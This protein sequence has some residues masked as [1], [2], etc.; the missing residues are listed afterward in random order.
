MTKRVVEQLEFRKPLPV[1]EGN[2]DYLAYEAELIGI[3]RLLT[4]SGLEDVYVEKGLAGWLQELRVAAEKE[5]RRFTLPSVKALAQHQR[6][7]RQALRCNI[8]RELTEKEYRKFS[9]RLAESPLLQWFCRVDR[10]EKSLVP[11]KSTLERYDKMIPQSDV[12]VLVDRLNRQTMDEAERLHL[13]EAFTLDVCLSDTTCVKA[14]IHFPTDWV[15]LRDGVRTLMK[16]VKVIRQHGL[17]HRMPD[18]DEFLRDINRLSIEMSQSRRRQDSEKRR[19]TVLRRMKRLTKLVQ[20]HAQRYCSRL[21]TDWKTETDLSEGQ[22]KQITRRMDG[23]LEQLPTAIR[24]A[25]ERI[26]GG[27]KV[28]NRDKI[29]SLYEPDI[30]VIVRKK[31]EAEVEFGNTL[32]LAEQE[33]GL[34]VDWKLEKGIS[35]GDIAL[36]EKSLT[37]MKEVFGKYPITMGGDRGFSSRACH[38]WL[39]KEKIGDAICPRSPQELTER[40]KNPTFR[41]IQRRRAQTEGRIGILKNDYLGRPLRSKRFEHRELAVTWAVLAHNLRLIARVVREAE[42]EKLKA[43]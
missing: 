29:L 8:A 33:D 1:V 21:Q 5:G 31:A 37:R 42:E 19:K 26:I 15:L 43:A 39:A 20:E 3:S 6:L 10:M 7:C 27:R 12:R 4:S 25:H 38:Q 36:M 9:R 35:P 17:R 23:I 11:G 34:I 14:N 41:N 28:E 40:M 30:H 18:P 32:L 24:Q 16:A 2:A 13:V 22:M